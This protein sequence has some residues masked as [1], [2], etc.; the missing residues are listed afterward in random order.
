MTE[1]EARK[2]LP[3]TV[4]YFGEDRTDLGTVRKLD[5]GGP[6]IEWE[7]GQKGWIAYQDMENVHIR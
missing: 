2:L 1:R 7:D 5:R 3:G 4:V 6:Y